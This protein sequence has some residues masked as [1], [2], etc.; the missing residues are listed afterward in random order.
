M[1]LMEYLQPNLKET[2]VRYP[3]TKGDLSVTTISNF[4]ICLLPLSEHGVSRVLGQ[5]R[6]EVHPQSCVG[7]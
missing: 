3:E 5:Q 6:L 7:S 4:E 2:G 1:D